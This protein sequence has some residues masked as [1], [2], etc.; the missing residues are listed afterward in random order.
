MAV[1]T[2]TLQVGGVF[3]AAFFEGHDVVTLRCQ[4]HTTLSP[5]FSTKG[6]TLEQLGSQRL[7]PSPGDPLH[8]R[9]LDPVGL[10]MLGAAT[11]SITDQHA[12]TWVS[13]RAWRGDWHEAPEWKKKTPPDLRMA[14]LDLGDGGWR[15]QTLGCLKCT[16]S[17]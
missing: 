8:W 6:F 9:S 14:G 7:K 15:H 3:S 16:Q 4:S 10:G 2:Q 17:L 11:R 5:A 1:V 13:A 12:T